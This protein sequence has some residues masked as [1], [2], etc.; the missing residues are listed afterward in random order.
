MLAKSL[1]FALSH[2]VMGIAWLTAYAYGVARLARAT[3]RPGF[4]I[5]LERTTGTVLI[6]LGV[7]LAIERRWG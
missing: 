2:D 5:W 3:G 4:R 6:G 1:L 7:R